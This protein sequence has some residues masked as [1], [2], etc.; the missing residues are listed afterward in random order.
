MRA[1]STR[2]DGMQSSR[3]VKP[4]LRCNRKLRNWLKWARPNTSTA[5]YINVA[6]TNR[7]G[8]PCVTSIT[9]SEDEPIGRALF[10][11]G[12]PTHIY[13]S[14]TRAGAISTVRPRRMMGRFRTSSPTS[15][16]SR[17]SWRIRLCHAFS[18]LRSEMPPQEL[19]AAVQA[20]KDDGAVSSLRGCDSICSCTVDLQLT[21]WP[22]STTSW[23]SCSSR[24][25]VG[26]L[27]R[28]GMQ[29]VAS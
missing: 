14:R 16:A 21:P 28:E 9:D 18:T 2:I 25:T 7:G 4:I 8:F 10:D 29:D 6:S 12:R 20:E 24:F 3:L 23:N 26:H 19:K 11:C 1:R 17:L 13:C 27:A 5:T 15:M 22:G